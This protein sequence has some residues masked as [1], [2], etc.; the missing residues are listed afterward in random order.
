MM[1]SHYTVLGVPFNATDREVRAAFVKLAA[2]LHPDTHDTDGAAFRE[3]S[4]AYGVLK[5]AGQR[6]VYDA[7]LLLL[8]PRCSDCNGSGAV[9]VQTGFRCTVIRCIAC[10]GLGKIV[11]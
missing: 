9:S 7:E 4:E 1:C 10:N 5:D 3:V 11:S 8:S 6:L 2:A